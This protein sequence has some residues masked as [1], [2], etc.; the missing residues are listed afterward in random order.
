LSK[1][2][3]KEEAAGKMRVFAMVDTITQWVLGP[4]HDKIFHILSRIPQDGTFDQTK[5]L[6]A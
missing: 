5:P 2:G 1:L 6:L 4:L 3:F